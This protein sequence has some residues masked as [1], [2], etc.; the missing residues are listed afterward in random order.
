MKTGL[1][2]LLNISCQFNVVFYKDATFDS[3]CN[4]IIPNDLT[5]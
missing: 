2:A 3:C 5:G 4:G 1:L